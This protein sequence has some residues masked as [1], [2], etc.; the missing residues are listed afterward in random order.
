MKELA[1]QLEAQTGGIVVHRAGGS[2]YLYRSEPW[3]R[4]P[5]PQPLG[6]AL[7]LEAAGLE[8]SVGAAETGAVEAGSAAE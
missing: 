6:P 2:I 3:P 5:P 8:S 4:Q 1:A 7:G